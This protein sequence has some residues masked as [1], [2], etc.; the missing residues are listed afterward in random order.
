MSGWL[1]TT[2]KIHTVFQIEKRNCFMRLHPGCICIS[3]IFRCN[4]YTF[5]TFVADAIFKVIA[6]PY[7]LHWSIFLDLGLGN[8]LEL[9]KLKVTYFRWSDTSYTP[10]SNPLKD[11]HS[12]QFDKLP[13]LAKNV[14]PFPASFLPGTFQLRFISRGSSCRAD[15]QLRTKVTRMSRKASFDLKVV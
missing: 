10:T 11:F 2:I 1:I 15:F 3:L 4:I 14:Q 6:A 9:H 7:L 5:E 12:Y 13:N 8:K